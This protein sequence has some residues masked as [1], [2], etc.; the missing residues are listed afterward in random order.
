MGER[1]IFV[2]GADF[3]GTTMLD[4][5]LGSAR[6]AASLGEF[7]AFLNPTST[8]HLQPECSCG[9]LA[10]DLWQ[11]EQFDA[12]DPYAR[13]FKWHGTPALVD[14][15]KD[16][17]SLLAT[18]PRLKKQ[19]V[20]ARIVLIWKDPGAYAKSCAQRGRGS[21]WAAKWLRYHRGFLQAG[22]PFYSQ[23]LDTLLSQ[24]DRALPDLCAFAGLEFADDL[25]AYGA[26]KHHIAFGSTTARMKLHA[27]GSDA[28]ERE[29]SRT[30]RADLRGESAPTPAQATATQQAQLD[31][32]TALLDEDGLKSPPHIGG[33]WAK[34]ALVSRKRAERAIYR[35]GLD[36][37][38]VS[39]LWRRKTA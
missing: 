15:S 23:R 9:D 6:D 25:M 2:M 17:S 36:P 27:E 28:W 38:K 33:V 3:S 21:D 12:D 29:V 26:R 19:Q 24:P 4:L 14:S 1:V 34:H 8:R 35:L 22:L 20:D 31:A 18:L 5:V 11:R 7:S 13:P 39:A 16:L 37:R 32:I 10:C 30:N